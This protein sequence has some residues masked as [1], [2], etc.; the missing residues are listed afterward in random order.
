MRVFF[1]GCGQ[2]GNRIADVFF[3]AAKKIKQKRYLKEEILTG[4]LAVNTARPDLYGLMNIPDKQ[5]ILF[6]DKDNRSRGAG[7]DNEL[8]AH[9]A[10]DNFS[11]ITRAI[12][13]D[14]KEFSG[15]TDAI[16]VAGATGGGTGSGSVP[17]IIDRMRKH[18]GSS[19]PIY[20]LLV[21]PFEYEEDEERYFYN[22]ATCL[23]T[24]YE[25]ADAVIL[26]DNQSYVKRDVSLLVIAD[27]ERE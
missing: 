7:K 15:K 1:M 20:A 6:R 22:T 19:I 13:D 2:C 5:R 23:K 3:E 12:T 4:V 26:I 8:G 14:M 27:A 25:V 24:T 10:N 17:V 11:K 16:I 18:Y 21:L 9:L